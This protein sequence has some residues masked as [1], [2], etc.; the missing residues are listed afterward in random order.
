MVLGIRSTVYGKM[1]K[2]AVLLSFLFCI[3]IADFSK[4]S[5]EKEEPEFSDRDDDYLKYKESTPLFSSGSNQQ[6]NLYYPTDT[7]SGVRPP[8]SQCVCPQGAP[9]VSGNP[10]SP[11][12]PGVP[13]IN[14][15]PG[16]PGPRGPP[17]RT[18]ALNFFC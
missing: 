10:G 5:K 13:G 6:G 8:T 2:L 17:G 4:S 12:I 7:L 1:N 15:N 16:L 18:E 14:G 11:G 3:K 9:G